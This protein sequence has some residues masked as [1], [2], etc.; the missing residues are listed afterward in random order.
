[1]QIIYE[2]T[3]HPF[4]IDFDSKEEAMQYVEKQGEGRVVT[5]VKGYDG[6]ERSSAMIVFKHGQWHGVDIDR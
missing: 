4:R 2:A 3:A 5:F 1:M 6:R